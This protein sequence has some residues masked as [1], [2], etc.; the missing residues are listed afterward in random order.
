MK[1]RLHSQ[2]FAST[3]IRR[4]I[5]KQVQSTTKAPEKAEE[6]ISQPTTV[7]RMAKQIHRLVVR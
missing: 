5:C 7:E 1:R 2:S 6:N 3:E 4:S